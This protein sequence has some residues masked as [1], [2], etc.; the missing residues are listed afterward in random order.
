MTY[1]SFATFRAY[2]K[3]SNAQNNIC[4]IIQQITLLFTHHSNKYDY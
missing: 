1:E 4:L 2:I 3:Y